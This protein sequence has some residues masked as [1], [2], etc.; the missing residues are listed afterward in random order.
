[1]KVQNII[2]LV[3]A[4]ACGLAAVFLTRDYINTQIDDYK[5]V[6][7]D[8][9]KPIEVI[10]A[11]R[12][13]QRGEVLSKHMLAIRNVPSG[14]VHKDAI[15]PGEVESIIGHKLVY[16][17]NGGES[18]LATHVALSKGDT[19]SNLIDGGKRAISFPVD[20]LSS[21]TGM[22]SPGDMIDLLV[23]L[24]DDGVEKTI[25]LLTSV[26]VIATGNTTDEIAGP[27]SAGRKAGF[28]TIT[29]HV[30]PADAAKITIARAEGDITV[31][32]RSRS[33]V[34]KLQLAAV[35]KNTLFGR[36]NRQLKAASTGPRIIRPT[37]KSK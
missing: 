27:E 14:F 6:I 26:V 33:D 36:K 17:L 4:L 28:Q 7:D 2:M 18:L 35:T 10:V 19:F 25:P 5:A 37:R 22:L 16:S 24:D 32:L 3:I 20:V 13:L 34:D 8:K 12:G 15:R 23:T 21:L 31:L 30:T 29:L 11:T 1:M 9:Y